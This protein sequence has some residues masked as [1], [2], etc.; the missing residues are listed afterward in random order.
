MASGGWSSGH[1]Y[2]SPLGNEFYS[3]VPLFIHTGTVELLYEDH[4]KYVDRMR[5]NGTKVELFETPDAPHD[6]FGAGLILGFIKQAHD[7]SDR[8]VRFVDEVGAADGGPGAF[9]SGIQL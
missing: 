1:P 5:K 6:G 9:S 3:A 8:A 4:V 7:A 2:L